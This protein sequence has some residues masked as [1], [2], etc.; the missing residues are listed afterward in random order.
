MSQPND[1]NE[2]PPA[3]AGSTGVVA[4]LGD[5]AALRIIVKQ[6]R[7]EI[8][9]L[10]EA[11]RR[12]GERDATLSTRGRDVVVTMD[13]TLTGEERITILAMAC[14]CDTRAGAEWHKSSAIL[15]GLLDRTR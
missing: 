2:P 8:E 6:Q 13:A 5:D 7:K 3:S 11:I 1:T 14:L 4:V 15:R 9:C 10:K 12:I